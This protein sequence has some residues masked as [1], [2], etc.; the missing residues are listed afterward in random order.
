MAA[1][2]RVDDSSH[3]RPNQQNC[4]E[5]GYHLALDIITLLRSATPLGYLIP[6]PRP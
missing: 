1:V 5:P 3:Y 4:H 2:N 6:R